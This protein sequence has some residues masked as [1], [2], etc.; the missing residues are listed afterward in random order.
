MNHPK[1][2]KSIEANE[3]RNRYSTEA[4]DRTIIKII[5]GNIDRGREAMDLM[6]K[7]IEEN[8]IDIA[9]M[10]EPNRK[11]VTSS[12]W[13][14]DNKVDVAIK[15]CYGGIKIENKGAGDGFVWI[16]TKTMVIYGCYISPNV[17]IPEFER[18]LSDLRTSMKSHNKETL[19]GGD[20]NAKSYLW[21]P[22]VEDR[23]GE[24]LAEW[25]AEDNLVVHNQGEAPTFIRGD[26][27][28]YIDIT[29]STEKMAKKVS[30]WKVL[31]EESLSYHRHILYEVST[32]RKKPNEG[33]P[34]NT[35]WR[36]KKEL[37]KEFTQEVGRLIQIEEENTLGTEKLSGLISK[38][39]NKVFPKKTKNARNP[40][41]WWCDEV[42][43][44][45]K[46]CLKHRRAA[47]RANKR[48]NDSEKSECQ[49]KFRESRAALKKSIKEAKRNAWTK[50]LN[51]IDTDIW[52][53]GY[54]IVTR[55]IT[56]PTISLTDEQQTEI[57]EKLF[58]T[59]PCSV[60]AKLPFNSSE[61]PLFTSEELLK[62]AK[63]LKEKKAPGPDGIP[64]EIVKIVVREHTQ[65][66]VD[67]LN[68][69][70]LKGEYPTEWKVAKL[71]LIEKHKPDQTEK[72]YRPICLLNVLGKLLERLILNRLNEEIERSGGLATQQH[73]FQEGKSTISALKKVQG[74]AD[75]A[76]SKPQRT[77]EL[78]LVITLDIQN[79]FNSAPWEGI[80]EELRKRNIEP[81]LYNIIASYLEN[82][83]LM[84]GD[85][86]TMNMTCGVPQGSV[87]GPTLWNVY[88]DGV[89]RIPAPWGVEL[90]GYA[91]DLAVV[92]TART[93]EE[94]IRGAN[95]ALASISQW[96]SSKQLKLAAQKT[97]AVLLVG[98]RRVPSVQ[99][100]VE[101]TMI[102]TKEA[103]KYLGI[104]FD[105]NMRM[106]QH[107]LKT[108]EK[109]TKALGNISRIMPNIGGPSE[110]SR[111]ILCSVVHSIILYG[112]S[113]W[114]RALKQ[115]QH[116]KK[117]L[118][119]QRKVA[120]RI[121]SAYKTTSTKALLVLANT[122]PIDLL[123]EERTMIERGENRTQARTTTLERWQTEWMQADGTAEWTKRL[124][125]DIRPWVNRERGETN[126]Y[127][128]QILTGHGCFQAYLH[129]MTI[130]NTKECLY[131]GKEDT[132]EHTFFECVRWQ[133]LRERANTDIGILTPENLIEKMLSSEKCWKAISITATAIMS[134]KRAELSRSQGD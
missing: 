90:I 14:C 84:I 98:G 39:C 103:L 49:E 80:L 60:W 41:Y 134:A 92:V 57:A 23:R 123:V 110:S 54:Q 31:E 75:E 24:I 67:V 102:E 125:K 65:L 56:A 88:Y 4:Q 131:C 48:N 16:E 118:S 19:V 69:T 59:H 45:R 94:I 114:G 62:A 86:R 115:K 47:V 107:I 82:R 126:F 34:K 113:I 38:A 133:E 99:V 112:A 97:E 3:N 17:G 28:S 117:L 11:K 89:L 121:T 26:S 8:N 81:Y 124:I 77:K 30:N 78:C 100:E 73:G 108:A 111:R 63:R 93:S 101:G 9:I 37:I 21:S 119:V 66:C 68:H 128:T 15:V 83:T 35:G 5:Q 106:G 13:I 61:V 129:R 55:R 105:R 130:S 116:L 79:A 85:K 51:E 46:E 53:K 72:A 2:P 44:K 127:L 27:K 95:R 32:E 104:H 1:N 7:I 87:L 12:S 70:L 36:I 40:I 20:F 71:V 50:V 91:D 52:G 132:A 6:N 122:P 22:K 96:L 10:A 58:P 25:L 42:S 64:A 18:F 43:Q 120:I 109:A 74:L 76:N 33:P 29:F